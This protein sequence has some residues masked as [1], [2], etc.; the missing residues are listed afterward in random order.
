MQSQTEITPITSSRENEKRKDLLSNLQI[1][2]KQNVKDK[3]FALSTKNQNKR[4]RGQTR[5]KIILQ[6]ISL[7]RV[8]AP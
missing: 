8:E 1:E 4:I 7:E 2:R 6:Q 3:S 5:K